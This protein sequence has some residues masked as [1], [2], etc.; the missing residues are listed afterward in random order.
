MKAG[1]GERGRVG[2]VGRWHACLV[3]EGKKFVCFI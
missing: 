2:E 3:L 1:R